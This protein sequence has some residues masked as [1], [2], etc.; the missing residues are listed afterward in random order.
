MQMLGKAKRVKI[1][2]A[3]RPSSS[4]APSLAEAL[5]PVVVLVGLLG[6][7]FRLFGDA[8]AAGPNQIALL[9]CVLVATFVAWRRGHSIEALRE[10]ATTS[11]TTGLSSIFILLAVGALIG[12]W[13]MSG[14]LVAMVYYGLQ[15]LNPHYFYMTACLLCAVIAFSIGSSWTVAGTVG[16][17]LELPR[18]WGLILP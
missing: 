6:L 8:A 1:M 9:F 16:I 15:L 11:V 3:S 10:A 4:E 17:G 7:S 13:A 5:V 14:T 12:T 2:F 18:G